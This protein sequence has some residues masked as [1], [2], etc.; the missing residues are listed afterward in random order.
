MLFTLFIRN[1]FETKL[2]RQMVPSI[3]K[4]VASKI[5]KLIKILFCYA[6]WRALIVV[7]STENPPVSLIRVQHLK[8]GHIGPAASRK[9]SIF[10]AVLQNCIQGEPRR[11]II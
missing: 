4:F 5:Q 3:M 10:V 8:C 11:A 1:C 9:L 7:A 2:A 6:R